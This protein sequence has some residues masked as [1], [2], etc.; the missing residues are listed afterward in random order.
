MPRFQLKEGKCLFVDATVYDEKKWRPTDRKKPDDI[1]FA[2]VM[3]KSTSPATYLKL[4]DAAAFITRFIVLGVD[5]DLI[6]QIL[7]SEYGKKVTAP[8]TEVASVLEMIGPFLEP[9]TYERP[10]ASPKHHG[11]GQHSGKYDL[12]FRVNFFNVGA[13]KGPL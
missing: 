7:L 4:N 13:L 3:D 2:H 11:K 10:Y 9:R 12:D 8:V 1:A 6:P 5:T